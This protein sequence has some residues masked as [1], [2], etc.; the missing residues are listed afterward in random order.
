MP[1]EEPGVVP[2]PV[3]VDGTSLGLEEFDTVARR[4]ASC[5]L[6][7]PARAAVEA[8]QAAVRRVLDSCAMPST[9]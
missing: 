6:A 8:G 3:P 7:E 9:A 4:G 2:G 1:L 5:V